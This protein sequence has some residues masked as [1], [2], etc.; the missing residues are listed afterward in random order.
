MK[1]SGYIAL[2]GRPN[3]GK[4]T[5]LNAL[6]ESELSIVSR[7]A[8]TTRERVAG[9][10]SQPRGQIVFLDTPGIHR[11]KEGGLNQFMVAES[12]RALESP[13]IVWYLVDPFS[14]EKHEQIVI[15]LLAESAIVVEKIPVILLM[16]K[17]DPETKVREQELFSFE[18]TLRDLLLNSGL[19]LVNTYR[20]SGKFKKGTSNLLEECWNLLP[21][22]V[23][24]FQDREQLSD[25]PLRFFVSEKIRKNLFVHLGEEVPYSC[26]VQ[27]ERFDET[28]IPQR[29]EAT[30]FV[31]RDSQKGIVIGKN[32]QKIKQI[33]Q[34]SRTDIEELLGARVFLGLKVKV[35]E[36]WSQNLTH[37]Q[38]LGYQ[39]GRT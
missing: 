33:G 35:L 32:G 16:N 25:R 3:S 39:K 20:I 31:E 37:L 7:K 12:K 28:S 8:Q 11:A 24:F 19:N 29:I 18:G 22:G 2:V 17:I 4:S 15:D 1:K 27:I 6:L 5:L 26:S 30:V 34:S 10:L 9:I 21:E 23:P 36:D 14:T 13:H 38:T